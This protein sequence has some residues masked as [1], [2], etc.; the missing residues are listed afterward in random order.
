MGRPKY[1]MLNPTEA[2]GDMRNLIKKPKWAAQQRPSGVG[3]TL[4]FACGL[5]LDLALCH[6]IATFRGELSVWPAAYGHC[7][8]NHAD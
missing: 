1:C 3:R 8:L 5:Q 2:E 7:S 6:S 4:L